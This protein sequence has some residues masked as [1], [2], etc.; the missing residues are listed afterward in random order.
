M[1]LPYVA[2]NRWLAEHVLPHEA[3][4][5]ARLRRLTR[6]SKSDIDDVIQE[7]YAILARLESVEGIR[8]PRTYAL[9]VAKS[10]FLQSIR[11]R[12]LPMIIEV[13]L[14]LGGSLRKRMIICPSRLGPRSAITRSSG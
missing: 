5:R 8:N 6:D 14:A 4:I 1:N 9:Q 12:N 11:R 10:V 7:T 3:M 2:R 13:V